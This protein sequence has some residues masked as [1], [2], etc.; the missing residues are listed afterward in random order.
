VSLGFGAD[1]KRIRRRVTGPTK[2]AVLEAMAELREELG[3][4]PKSTRTYTVAEAVAA[5]LADGLPGRSERT[6]TIYKDGLAPLLAK[7]GQRPLR[8]LTAVEVR[9]G[10]ESLA[11]QLSTRS[12]Q[13]AR[14]ALERAIRFAQVHERVG[15]NAAE[16][17]EAPRGRTGRPSKSL[18]LVQAQ[19]L[20][21]AAESGRWYCY[22]TLPLLS[23]LRTE[24]VRAV[25]WDHVVA[26][27]EDDAEWR[28]VEEAGLDR[29]MLA[30]H[31]W[32]ADRTGGDVK[33]RKSRRSLRLPDLCVEALRNHQE[34]QRRERLIAGEKWQEN[35][36]VFASMVGTPVGARNVR[37]AF[38][39]IIRRAGIEGQWTPR[40]L[41]TSFVSLMSTTGMPIEEISR[42]VGHSSTVVTET[43][44]RQ[45]LRPVIRTGADAMDRLFP[46]SAPKPGRASDKRPDADPPVGTVR[47][48]SKRS[49]DTIKAGE[50]AQVRRKRRVVG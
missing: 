50:D 17:I 40:E 32:R 38:Q 4:A 24:E 44:Y 2:T 35:G 27:V 5:W 29:D 33:T 48:R 18:F 14:N 13:I 43:V 6:T 25:G 26:W 37:R 3:R 45:E 34:Q 15:R 12:L 46:G 21:K 31:V 41:R 23:G 1:G 8:E 7:I 49:T 19:A 39:A 36:L 30:I 42:L 28:P 10:L 22:I 16:L 11:G 9:K 47:R 20:L